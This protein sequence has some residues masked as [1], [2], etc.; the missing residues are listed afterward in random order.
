M[1]RDLNTLEIV[2][3]EQHCKS[4]TEEIVCISYEQPKECEK[5]GLDYFIPNCCTV[6]T[7]AH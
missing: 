2:S 6:A 7:D 4:R 5:E 3:N 1:C